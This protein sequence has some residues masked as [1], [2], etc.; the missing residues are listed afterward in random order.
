MSRLDGLASLEQG[1]EEAEVSY[2]ARAEK[3][4]TGFY[5]FSKL[6]MSMMLT[7]AVP[8]TIGDFP[9]PCGLNLTCLISRVF[10]H[11]LPLLG[12]SS[13]WFH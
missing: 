5:R 6:F 3:V 4:H 13:R 12:T 8:A 7:G 10:D 11:H 9:D 1:E 2:S